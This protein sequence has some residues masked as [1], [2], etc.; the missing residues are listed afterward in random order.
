[1]IAFAKNRWTPDTPSI[2]DLERLTID[3][4][5]V[6]AKYKRSIK[7]PFK[8]ALVQYVKSLGNLAKGL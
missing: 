3:E 6:I 5:I 8:K 2:S 1:M 4:L 7:H